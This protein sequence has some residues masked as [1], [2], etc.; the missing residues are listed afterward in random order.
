MTSTVRLRAVAA[1]CAVT[2]AAGVVAVVVAGGERPD[3]GMN[4][5]AGAGHVEAEPITS[6][7][8]T[9]ESVDDPAPTT[10]SPGDPGT[11]G[12]T[13]APRTGTGT[14]PGRRSAAG[15]STGGRSGNRSSADTGPT[16]SDPEHPPVP[17]APTGQPGSETKTKSNCYALPTAPPHVLAMLPADCNIGWPEP[18]PVGIDGFELRV[19]TAARHHRAGDPVAVT[20]TACNRRTTALHQTFAQRD[21]VFVEAV[22][23]SL[24][25]RYGADTT[26]DG[27][28]YY[29]PGNQVHGPKGSEVSYG[30]GRRYSS[31]AMTWWDGPHRSA[32]EIV[33]WAPGECK[34]IPVGDWLQGNQRY[35][36]DQCRAVG[37]WRPCGWSEPPPF[38]LGRVRPGDYVLRAHWGGVEAGGEQRQVIAESPPF[39]LEGLTLHL[40]VDGARAPDLETPSYLSPEFRAGQPIELAVVACNETDVR[41]TDLDGPSDTTNSRRFDLELDGSIHS[42]RSNA[43]RPRFHALMGDEPLTVEPGGCR[44]W[45]FSWDQRFGDEPAAEGERVSLRLWWNPGIEREPATQLIGTS[46]F[47]GCGGRAI[48]TPERRC[49]P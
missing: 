33:S 10:A 45:A 26:D 9:V 19:A 47:V 49:L 16:S 27:R 48:D 38:P 6:V 2:L 32:D 40:E 43:E 23:T 22:A 36:Q 13:E 21:W 18:M 44:R 4:L 41:F 8:P 5:A 37:S 14:R 30:T 42:A 39:S 31:L 1:L 25:G 3:L 12:Q 35:D 20:V 17:A 29:D 28:F 46:F 34:A 24:D 15:R 7:E 11:T